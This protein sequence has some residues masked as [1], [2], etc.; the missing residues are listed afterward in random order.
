MDWKS[1]PCRNRTSNPVFHGQWFRLIVQR[2]GRRKIPPCGRLI[3]YK[4]PHSPFQKLVDSQRRRYGLSGRELAE[5]IDVSQSTLWIW[6]HNVNGFPHHLAKLRA[7]YH[8]EPLSRRRGG[9]VTLQRRADGPRPNFR[10]FPLGFRELNAGASRSEAKLIY[11]GPALPE[12]RFSR[13]DSVAG[14]RIP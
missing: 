4:E 1:A 12:G 8:Q 13:A 5:K 14:N 11:F 7:Q 9:K 3:E 2:R 6:L 10:V